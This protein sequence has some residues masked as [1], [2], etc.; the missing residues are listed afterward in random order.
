MKD[1]NAW[2]PEPEPAGDPRIEATTDL[3][4]WIWSCQLQIHRFHESTHLEFAGGDDANRDMRRVYSRAS[5]DEHL[6]MVVGGQFVR[7]V[8]RARVHYPHFLLGSSEYTALTLLRNIYEHWDETRDMFRDSSIPKKKSSKT[9]TEN[10][11][12]GRPWSV[13]YTSDG[14]LLSGV[15]LTRDLLN[16]LNRLECEVLALE[17]DT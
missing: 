12:Q 8:E 16:E 10:F 3:M 5:L 6:L 1:Y 14:P 4:H 17:T 9:F 15:V 2:I 13:T 7:A 11:P